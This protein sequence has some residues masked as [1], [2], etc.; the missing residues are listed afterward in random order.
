M[1][2]HQSLTNLFRSSQ[3]LPPSS[4]CFGIQGRLLGTEATQR[5]TSM[6]IVECADRH[7]KARSLAEPDRLWGVNHYLGTFDSGGMLRQSMVSFHCLDSLFQHDERI[8]LTLYFCLQRGPTL[9]CTEKRLP[10]KPPTRRR[11]AAAAYEQERHCLR[12]I[13]EPAAAQPE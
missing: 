11:E 2:V 6:P 9:S 10:G 5:G 13:P 1:S 8:D 3:D 4:P 12:K 7:E